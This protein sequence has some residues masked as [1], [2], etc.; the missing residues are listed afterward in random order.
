MLFIHQEEGQKGAD[1]GPDVNGRA[2]GVRQPGG[3]HRAAGVR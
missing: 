2:A 3:V 1:V